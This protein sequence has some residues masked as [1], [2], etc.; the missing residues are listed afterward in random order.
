MQ[1]QS[2]HYEVGPFL[3]MFNCSLLIQKHAY[4]LTLYSDQREILIGQCCVGYKYIVSLCDTVSCFTE[5]VL[6]GMY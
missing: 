4:S 5:F 2:I 1:L 3:F 6:F